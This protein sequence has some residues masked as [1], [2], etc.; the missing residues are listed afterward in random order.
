M[1]IAERNKIR[2]YIAK[3]D[4]RKKE[5]NA[6]YNPTTGEG[7]YS[8]ERKDFHVPDMGIAHYKIPFDC[9]D[10]KIIRDLH[11]LGSVRAYLKALHL[12]YT[13]SNV[14]LVKRE[15][16]KARCKHDFEFCAANYFWINDGDSEKPRDVLFV[17]NRSQRDL[18]KI[19]YDG[20][21]YGK[22]VRV[23]IDKSRQQGFSTLTQL[24]FA[25][26]QTFVYHGV[27]SCIVAHVEN[28]ARVIRGMFTNM[29]KKLPPWLLGMEKQPSLTPFE[30]GNKTL[31][32][33][34]IGSRVTIG[35]AEKPNNI[36]G[37]KLSLVHFSEVGL[38][39]TTQGIKPEQLIQSILGG[40]AYAPNTIVVY[41]ST[42]RGVGN[43]FHSEWL[44]AINGD[45]VYTPL[46]RAWY[47]LDRDTLAIDDYEKF[48]LS[49]SFY[50][51][52]LF[53]I[54]ATLE[55]INWYREASRQFRDK[56]RWK[57]E[58]PSSWQE[59]F[60][61]TGHRLYPQ[62]DVMRLRKGVR[63]P[64]FVGDIY[65]AK[66]YGEEALMGID[67][68][69]ERDG[70]LKVWLMPDKSPQN[71]CNDRYV[72]VMDIG[73]C[74]DHS[75]RSVICVLDRYDMTRGG[76]PIVAAEWCGHI[77]HDLLAWKA[78]QIAT[79]YDNA[80]LV[81]ES[82]TLETEQ[83]EGDHFDYILD[84]IA[85]HYDNLWCRTPA[86]KIKMGFDPKWGFHTNKSTKR[87]VCD[88]QK[89][90]LRENMYI[91]TCAEA[92]DEHDFMEVKSNG[93]L[94]AVDGQHDDRHI[95]R[96]IGVWICYDYLNPPRRRADGAIRQ[97]KTTKII[98]ESTI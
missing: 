62:D 86:D 71:R 52:W 70:P 58:R 34:G 82:N 54:G 30:R 96:A 19:F 75:D 10:E 76:V 28:T 56:W 94:G 46:F 18:L 98:N 87:M 57:S 67:F 91:E 43:F 65:G 42:A 92:C 59:S 29:L 85:Y 9:F 38:Y 6:I 88:H 84:E 83:T 4:E 47:L 25:W 90:A 14:E 35:S 24:F 31:I 5:R 74:S 93:S 51:Q 37:D 41:E 3:N 68:K 36:V 23:I 22:P 81:I 60:Q 26:F 77:D 8:C 17:L 39:K 11:A 32:I 49:M 40:V 50:E 95:T 78:A 7:C 15:Y 73:G 20:L 89:K 13:R 21:K 97:K 63:E 2:T 61:S 1:T 80:L 48:I 64:I 55:G 79:A 12:R 27:N 53:D 69:E 33:K 72:V 44:A 66:P 16:I 45:S